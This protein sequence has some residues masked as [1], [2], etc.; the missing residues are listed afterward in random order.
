MVLVRSMYPPLDLKL[1][2][3]RVDKLVLCVGQL[4]LFAQ[5]MSLIPS[6]IEWI[7][8]GLTEMDRHLI[9]LRKALLEIDEHNCKNVNFNIS[10]V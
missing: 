8:G 10:Q 2:E 7:Y 5:H 3:T 9:A 1:L 4:G 6:D